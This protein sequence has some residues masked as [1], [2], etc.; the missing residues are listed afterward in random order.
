MICCWLIYTVAYLTRNTYPASIVHLTGAELMTQSA[1]GFISTCYFIT[2]GAGHLING[3]LA[4]RISPVFMLITGICGTAAANIAMI[5]TLPNV[6]LSASVWCLNGWFESMLWAPIVALLSGMIAPSLRRRAMEAVSVTRPTGVILAYLITALCS[7]CGAGIGIPY[8]IAAVCAAVTCVLFSVISKRAYSAPDTV[9]V[10]AERAEKTGSEKAPVMKALAASGA[11]I[12]AL[13]AV[14]H[15]M[16]KDGVN[17]WVPSLLRDS[18]RTTDAFSTM[19][20]IAIPIAGVVGILLANFLL[21]RKRLGGNHS[22]IGIILMLAA[23][24]PAAVLIRAE[25]IPLPAGVACLCLVSLLME[26]FC[27]V[28][29]VMM[30]TEFAKYGRASTVSGIFNSLIYVGSAVSTYTFGAVAERIGWSGTAVIWLSLS[31]ISAAVLAFAVKP[32]SRFL[33]PAKKL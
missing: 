21:G 14:F 26:S 9:D 3:F 25:A 29:S 28:F 11:L 17:T 33:D 13:P 10:T 30:P 5:F 32:W 19:L 31:L 24:V 7:Y 6:P 8:V 1:A 15:G 12:F 2:Y 22:V 18:F 16:L 23:A 20:A 27:H 4:D